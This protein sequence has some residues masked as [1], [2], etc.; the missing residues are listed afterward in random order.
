MENNSNIKEIK[1]MIENI[2]IKSPIKTNID[3]EY[4]S[5]G[6]K[7]RDIILGGNNN[8]YLND[9]IKLKYK[10][11]EKLFQI[12]KKRMNQN[13][14]IFYKIKKLLYVSN[15]FDTRIL[16]KNIL[17]FYLKKEIYLDKYKTNKKKEE[18]YN[19]C[20]IMNQKGINNNLKNKL[21]NKDINYVSK[22][23]NNNILH[24][25]H[26]IINSNKNFDSKEMDN[27]NE[28]NDININNDSNSNLFMK[29][30]A[31]NFYC[32]NSNTD[33][34][35]Y[36]NIASIYT[37]RTN[38]N[39]NINK[40][41]FSPFFQYNN[42]N[43]KKIGGETPT[44]LNN[45]KTYRPTK[46]IKNNYKN[47]NNIFLSE[48]LNDDY[49]AQ[50][51]NPKR[52]NNLY[53]NYLN[54]NINTDRKIYE[55]NNFLNSKKNITLS[56]EMKNLC[57]KEIV[58]NY[59]HNQQLSFDGL[60][61]NLKNEF[62][63]DYLKNN[64]YKD[65][66]NHKPNNNKYITYNNIININEPQ[67]IH[68]DINLIK[69]YENKTPNIQTYIISFRNRNNQKSPIDNSYKDII[70]HR[71]KSSSSFRSANKILNQYFPKKIF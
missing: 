61:K 70:Y 3:T 12:I 60:R 45:N 18:Y 17:P 38:I 71:P 4:I 19:K 65:I 32:N 25:N 13:K 67:I 9:N 22:T 49:Q 53:S 31:P 62:S 68:K 14:F 15:T 54:N 46:I 26:N 35:N 1:R 27:E 24:Y 41:L 30:T 8:N 57:F 48:N 6:L 51:Y 23:H 55:K 33:R 56:N 66:N 37:K 59:N 52:E 43:N 44:I 39:K 42:Y 16:K 11:L 7:K 64:K 29:R 50:T 69:N 40:E 58:I 34:R 36:Y 63:N 21:F 20:N 10:L 2:N 28:L 47:I 5:F